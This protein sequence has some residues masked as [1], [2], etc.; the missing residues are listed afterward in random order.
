M[1]RVGWLAAL[2][3][4]AV[5]LAIVLAGC[6]GPPQPA[7][8]A[9][10]SQRPLRVATTTNIIT[11]LATIV[12]GTRV[13]VTGLMGAGVNPHL[14]KATAGDVQTVRSADLILYGGLDLEGRMGDLFAALEKVRPTVA[15]TR[16]IPVDRLRTLNEKSG[17]RDPH[18][19]FD[20]SLWET[21][22]R[23]VADAYSELDPRHRTYYQDRA[24]AY[25]ARLRVLDGWVKRRIAAIPARRRVLVTSH[26]A[27]GYF[28]DRYGM[29]V[30]AIQ[31]ASMMT[32]A[33]TDDV[34][35]VAQTVADRGVPAIFVESSLPPQTI[36]AV[37]A[38]ARQ[39]GQEV[40]VGGELYSD[41]AGDADTVEGTYIGMIHHN[42]N[43]IADALGGTRHTAR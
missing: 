5:L 17:M 41:S 3:G 43:A 4:L 12:G 10:L 27:F 6:S 7:S 40:R 29:R 8:P 32:E 9:E 14:Y 24:D 31:G 42:V 28:A 26:D 15:V 18:M 35:R 23:T 33:T 30:A 36:E 20:V 39:R 16:D 13:S 38:A 2:A 25:I 37:I 21:A 1:R 22:T 11:D 19:W 34:E